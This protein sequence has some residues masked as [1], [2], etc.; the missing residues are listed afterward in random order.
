MATNAAF[1]EEA[2]RIRELGHLNYQLIAKATGAAPSTVRDWLALRSAP[3]GVRAERL[4]ELAALVDRLARV[5]RA[6]YIP[7]W[8]SKPIEALDDRK[9]VELL[10]KGA[11]LPVARVVSSLEDPGAV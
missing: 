2:L 5:M 4:A 9:P 10:A 8:L 1:A 7:V 11:Y 6:E 3:T